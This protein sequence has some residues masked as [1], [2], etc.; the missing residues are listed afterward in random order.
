LTFGE[1]GHTSSS[2]YFD[3][4]PL[5]VKA[6][7]ALDEIMVHLEKLT[8]SLFDRILFGDSN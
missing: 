1:S 3:Q 6:W 8:V 4:A 5:F 2:Q 7:V